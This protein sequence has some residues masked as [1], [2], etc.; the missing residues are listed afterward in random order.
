MYKLSLLRDDV[1]L[2]NDLGET[3]RVDELKKELEKNRGIVANYNWH[4]AE[5]DTWEPD[6]HRMVLDYLENQEATEEV[7]NWFSKARDLFNGEHFAQINDIMNKAF[8]AQ[9][10]LLTFYR[11]AEEVDIEK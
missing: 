8:S 7:N 9:P 10:G 5:K 2:I 6:A 11:K 1:L 4:L 3:Y